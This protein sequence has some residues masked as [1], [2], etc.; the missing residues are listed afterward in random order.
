M[1]PLTDTH[2]PPVL[3]GSPAGQVTALYQAYATCL[4]RLAM[5]ML[6]D[7]QAAEDVVQEAFLGLYRRWGNLA[8]PGKALTYVRSSLLYQGTCF[9]G[10]AAVAWAGAAGT[11]IGVIAAERIV[12]TR[13]TTDW[14]VGVLAAGKFTPLRVPM[15]TDYDD[16]GQLAF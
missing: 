12:G 16:P 13:A 8:D 5:L 6:S 14:E 11:A 15:P 2:S 7:Q 1:D 3:A 10:E 4:V 9:S